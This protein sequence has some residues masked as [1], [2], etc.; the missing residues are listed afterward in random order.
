VAL[1]V[2]VVARE[3]GGRELGFHRGDLGV[4]VLDAVVQLSL[5]GQQVV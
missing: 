3:P 2:H 4:Q 5:A 1:R